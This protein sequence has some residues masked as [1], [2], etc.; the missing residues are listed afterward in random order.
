MNRP[1]P[2]KVEEHNRPLNDYYD[3]KIMVID[4]KG[5]PIFEVLNPSMQQ[6]EEIN[7]MVK[8]CNEQHNFQFSKH[9]SFVVKGTR[10]G[11]N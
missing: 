11:E 9:H 2:W 10:Q 8:V 3:S 5:Q 1:F 4:G 7:W 6:I